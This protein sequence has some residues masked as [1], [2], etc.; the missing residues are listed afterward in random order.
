MNASPVTTLTAASKWSGES[1]TIA[2]VLPSGRRVTIDCRGP[3]ESF[4]T[5]EAPTV[6]W[7]GIG[8]VGVEDA[9]DFAELLMFA[10]H[11]AA[12]LSG[13]TKGEAS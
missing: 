9:R 4:G 13:P 8:S 3:Q 2:L 11:T 1:A 10:V 7:G 5:P 6:N 12:T